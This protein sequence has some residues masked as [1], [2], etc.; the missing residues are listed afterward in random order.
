MPLFTAINFYM[1]KI[2]KSYLVTISG[3]FF[4]CYL[5]GS[6]WEMTYPDRAMIDDAYEPNYVSYKLDLAW[7]ANKILADVFSYQLK[8]AN[9][10]ASTPEDRYAIVNLRDRYWHWLRRDQNQQL[11]AD[12][13]DIYEWAKITIESEVA[14]CNEYAAITAILLL[15]YHY[16]YPSELW[17]Y[18]L[19]GENFDHTFMAI[20][21]PYEDSS[22][23]IAIDPW[24]GKAGYLSEISTHLN[25]AGIKVPLTE[26]YQFLPIKMTGNYNP[27]KHN[28]RDIKHHRSLYGGVN[29]PRN[30]SNSLGYMVPYQGPDMSYDPAIHK[31]I[32]IKE[33][34]KYALL[35][36]TIDK[37]Q[38][39][40]RIKEDF[41]K[42][43]GAKRTCSS[44]EHP[45]EKSPVLRSS[46]N[47]VLKSDLKDDVKNAFLRFANDHNLPCL[48]PCSH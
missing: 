31:I 22:N 9:S 7:V 25:E 10:V 3:L 45:D 42:F 47:K 1:K 21:R 29:T 48:F 37:V 4:A 8:T 28:F 12:I 19:D 26:D 27:D 11:Y 35:Q 13:D 36:S 15:E 33:G 32:E 30:L 41:I 39:C 17:V 5:N 44:S 34:D 23:W 24:L 16:Y 2:V 46:I 43:I 14:H 38:N 40:P 18:M 20:S 6:H